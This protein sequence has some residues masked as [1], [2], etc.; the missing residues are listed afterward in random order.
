MV[1]DL[2]VVRDNGCSRSTLAGYKGQGK[3]FMIERGGCSFSEKAYNAQQAG[4]K[5]VIIHDNVYETIL[6]M[7]GN[8]VYASAV[9]IPAV[10]ITRNAAEYIKKINTR[11]VSLSGSD[12]LPFTPPY[13]MLSW[14][15][16]VTFFF[17]F[18]LSLGVLVNRLCC[19]IPRRTYYVN[20]GIHEPSE[21]ATYVEFVEAEMMEDDDQEDKESAHDRANEEELDD[22]D[23]DTPTV[24]FPKND[25]L[26][27]PFLVSV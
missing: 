8:D 11:R 16:M 1:G 20:S 12:T 17:V 22:D 5:A 6:T 19:C 4:A 21:S 2:V 9:H 15:F 13:F 27:E 7:N 23:D 3:V 24:R 10:F 26:S 18:I 25:G 14:L